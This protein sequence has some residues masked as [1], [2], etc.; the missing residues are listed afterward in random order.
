MGTP[1]LHDIPIPWHRLG[2][3]SSMGGAL[4]PDLA[5]LTKNFTDATNYLLK[6]QKSEESLENGLD[7]TAF[8]RTLS[9]GT[10]I[11][12]VATTPGKDYFCVAVRRR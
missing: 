12:T 9:I 5:L 10:S 11:G 2:S 3:L 7:R 6:E 8:R 1:P 4:E